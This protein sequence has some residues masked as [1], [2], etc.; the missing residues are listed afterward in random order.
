MWMATALRDT[1][2]VLLFILIFYAALFPGFRHFDPFLCFVSPI[3]VCVLKIT[4][5]GSA[6]LRELVFSTVP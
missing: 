6:V 1:F 5:I 2:D 4:Q 3:S